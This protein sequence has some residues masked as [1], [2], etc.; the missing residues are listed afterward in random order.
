MGLV[1]DRADGPS[2]HKDILQTVI[3]VK[4]RVSLPYT[5]NAPVDSGKCN[6]VVIPGRGDTERPSTWNPVTVKL[7]RERVRILPGRREDETITIGG[8]EDTIVERGGRQDKAVVR[9]SQLTRPMPPRLETP[10]KSHIGP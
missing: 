6:E 10:W 2:L 1:E 5:G 4:R 8:K 7:G 3:P 9:I